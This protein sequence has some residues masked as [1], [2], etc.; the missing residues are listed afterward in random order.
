VHGPGAK[1]VGTLRQVDSPHGAAK[2]HLHPADN[3]VAALVLGHGAGGG[4]TAVDLV[5]A[6]D[7]A[8]SAGLSVALVEQ[9]YRVAGRRSPPPVARLDVS[10]TAVLDDLR[11]GELKGLPL[12]VGGRSLGARV[13]CRTAEATGAVAVLCLA[14][15]LQP[16]RRDG[17]P[18]QS[19]L[20][21]LDE[22]TVPTLVVQGASD[23]FGIPP[24][25]ASRTVVQVPG[26]HSL[27]TD[28]PAVAAA[29][30]E[31]LID[32]P[33][34]ARAAVDGRRAHGKQG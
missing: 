25:S 21:E 7:A 28:L 18:A 17:S 20:H 13:A 26:N 30:R 15:P 12:V 9:P 6:T 11:A 31:W 2:V 23:P 33:Y 8:L 10:W 19:R 4:V 24:P 1:P 32:L 14:F 22:V 27:R 29:V 3:A 16:P 5:A 34:A